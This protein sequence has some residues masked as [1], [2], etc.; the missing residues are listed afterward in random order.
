LT[1]LAYVRGASGRYE[2]PYNWVTCA[3]A[4][5]IAVSESVVESVRM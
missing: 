5:L 1:L 3:R 4:A 2:A